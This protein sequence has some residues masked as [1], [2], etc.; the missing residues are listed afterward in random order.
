MFCYQFLWELEIWKVVFY[1]IYFLCWSNWV[2]KVNYLIPVFIAWIMSGE[3]NAWINILEPK[4]NS[5]G[6][7][8]NKHPHNSSTSQW[9]KNWQKITST[10]ILLL[11]FFK[12]TLQQCFSS[13]EQ[14]YCRQKY[15]IHRQIFFIVL[16]IH[17]YNNVQLRV[18]PESCLNF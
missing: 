8:Y 3:G 7:R 13:L 10:L 2:K 17:F 12:M 6:S 14:T 4:S 1:M 11:G 15:K 5:G 18:T 9:F 16:F